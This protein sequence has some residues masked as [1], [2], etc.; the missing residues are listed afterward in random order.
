MWIEGDPVLHI[1]DRGTRYFVA[2]FMREESSEYAW[3]LFVEYWITVFTGYPYIILHDQ[4][5]NFRQNIFKL[6]APK[7]ESSQKG[8]LLN[9]ITRLVCANATIPWSDEFTIN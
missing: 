3:S 4:G 1:I 8:L 9:L 2:K 7:M 6:P 5:P